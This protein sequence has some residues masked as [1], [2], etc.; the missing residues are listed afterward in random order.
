MFVLVGV[1]WLVLRFL[2]L[3]PQPLEQLDRRQIRGPVFYL[4]TITVLY[5]LSGTSAVTH[6]MARL[7][8]CSYRP[9]TM[10]NLPPGRRAVV[11]L[12]S[13][14]YVARD[15]A[16]TTFP[17][18]DRASAE[19]RPRAGGGGDFASNVFVSVESTNPSRESINPEVV[20]ERMTV[21]LFGSGPIEALALEMTREL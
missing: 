9:F 20:N 4:S 13:G 8:A 15:W 10:E 21:S 1:V 14:S 12:G 3:P 18:L 5:A 19:H 7:L 17:L 6:T 11:V 16:G 2:K